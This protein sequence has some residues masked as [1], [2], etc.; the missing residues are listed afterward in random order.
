MI[1]DLAE[2]RRQR[3]EPQFMLCP[4]CEDATAMIPIVLQGQDGPFISGL[5]CVGP[6]CD[7]EGSFVEVVNG[8]PQLP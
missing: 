5:V 7:G 4:R 3:G 6:K 8:F 1:T 2:Y